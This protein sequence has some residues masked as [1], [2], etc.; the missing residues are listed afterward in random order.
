MCGSKGDRCEEMSE[1]PILNI[2]TNSPQLPRKHPTIQILIAQI[3]HRPSALMVHDY[4]G[5]SALRWT[6]NWLVHAHTDAVSVA[7]GDFV[8]CLG[9]MIWY[10]PGDGVEMAE[11]LEVVEAGD[12]VAGEIP[13]GS[14]CVG[15]AGFE[16]LNNA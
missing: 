16:G 3:T 2:N 8:H 1:V 14:G 13:R 4:Q 15:W 10:G 12:T 5:T 6:G 9:H 11:L 7:R